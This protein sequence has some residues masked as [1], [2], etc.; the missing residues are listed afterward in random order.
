MYISSVVFTMHTQA[1]SRH[2]VHVLF[3]YSSTRPN[4]AI[5]M[6]KLAKIHVC[7]GFGVRGFLSQNQRDAPRRRGA[8]L[9]LKIALSLSDSLALA[10]ISEMCHVRSEELWQCVCARV[11]AE[12]RRDGAG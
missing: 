4:V 11:C 1:L 12:R 3:G 6:E 5:A 7:G 10:L 9:S 8:P 2:A